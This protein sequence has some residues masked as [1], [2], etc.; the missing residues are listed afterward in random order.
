MK[1]LNFILTAIAL[2]ILAAVFR[3]YLLEGALKNF[4]ESAQS[5][6]ASNQ[7]MINSNGRL[8]TEIINLRKEVSAIKE[9]FSKK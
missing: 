2:A 1:Y 4:A 5:V 3:L 7:A 9:N 6:T 8:E